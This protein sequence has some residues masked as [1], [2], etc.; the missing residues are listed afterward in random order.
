[1]FD[2]FVARITGAAALVWIMA[3]GAAGAQTILTLGSGFKSPEGVAVDGSGNVF[4]ADEFSTAITEILAAGGYTAVKTL[5][6]GFSH[7]Q[8]VALDGNFNL[9]VF[10]DNGIKMA[11]AAT[12]YTTAAPIGN[13]FSGAD[14]LAVDSAGDAVIGFLNESGVREASA[15]SN[16]M[17][18]DQIATPG[19]GLPN[20]IA[21]DGS[22][23]LFVADSANNAVK[24]MTAASD[25]STVTTVATGFVDPQG[26]AVDSSANIF[27]ADT[28]DN[29][30][31][32]FFAAGGYAKSQILDANFKSPNGVAVDGSG[33][34]FVSGQTGLLEIPAGGTGRLLIKQSNFFTGV[35]VDASG[36]LFLSN[37][38]NFVITGNEVRKRM[39][40]DGFKTATVIGSGFSD[41]QGVAID[42]AGDVFVADTG[43]N[44]IEKVDGGPPALLASVL[45]DSR[46]IH[47]GATATVFATIINSGA[48]PLENCQ[49]STPVSTDF[50]LPSINMIYQTTE[51]TTNALTGQ[52]NTPVT[53]PGNNGVQTFLISF[54]SM[55]DAP[56]FTTA[57]APLDFSCSAG[58]VV[59]A[60][61]IIEGVNT[62]SLSASGTPVA[63]VIALAAT[64]THDGIVSLPEGGTGAF[65]VASFNVG[66]TQPLTVSVTSLQTTLPVTAT[67]CE[68]NPSTAQCLTPPSPTV[69]FTAMSGA[70]PTFSIFLQ[71]TGAIP[72]APATA[73]LFVSFLDASGN[74]HGS[75]S[76]AIETQ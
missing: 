15:A 26:I 75:T 45:P 23:N 7:P 42:A 14:A 50:A 10:D 41:P 54:Q 52:P 74:F 4:V 57:F 21:L 6:G 63:D 59:N 27:V 32:E 5:A 67:I 43:N 76:V 46:S 61:P 47:L 35:A 13:G 38:D 66:A 16:Y 58:N 68:T 69:S 8:G 36:N 1:V 33:N 65:A 31:T 24:E 60:A 73:R 22:G 11:P 51:P 48:D 70:A 20:A 71:S 40:A 53:I 29:A 30:V 12:G 19:V 34:I 18:V 25:Y 64:P 17:T 49:I 3:G 2:Q 55:S 9:Y 56:S 62:I 28:G 39:A 44:A 72:F 37:G